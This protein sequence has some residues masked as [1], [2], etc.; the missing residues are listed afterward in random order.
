MNALKVCGVPCVSQSCVHV[1]Q[2]GGD[3]VGSL[4]MLSLHFWAFV[5]F[6]LMPLFLKHW[7][8]QGHWFI[9]VMIFPSQLAESKWKVLYDKLLSFGGDGLIF[10]YLG[11]LGSWG[12][13]PGRLSSVL[14]PWCMV[15]IL[16]YHLCI[17]SKGLQ[18]FYLFSSALHFLSYFCIVMCFF[19]W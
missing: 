1:K 13:M 2:G 4:R 11:L 3:G 12:G 8:K 14:A 19:F 15:L 18:A 17:C 7:K 10:C 16:R 9:L 6:F 5:V